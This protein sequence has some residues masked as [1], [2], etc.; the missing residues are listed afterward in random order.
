MPYSLVQWLCWLWWYWV[1]LVLLVALAVRVLVNFRVVVA[2]EVLVGLFVLDVSVGQCSEGC[3]RCTLYH[4]THWGFLES[5][6]FDWYYNCFYHIKRSK[7]TGKGFAF[8]KINQQSPYTLKHVH[9]N[10]L[11]V[12]IK[13]P[14]C[15]ECAQPEPQPLQVFQETCQIWRE[16]W[17]LMR[18]LNKWNQRKKLSVTYLNIQPKDTTWTNLYIMSLFFCCEKTAEKNTICQLRNTAHSSL[19]APNRSDCNI[20]ANNQHSGEPMITRLLLLNIHKEPDQKIRKDE[21]TFVANSQRPTAKMWRYLILLIPVL[22]QQTGSVA[23]GERLKLH[24]KWWELSF[25][26]FFSDGIKAAYT[27]HCLVRPSKHTVTENSSL[28]RFQKFF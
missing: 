28:S 6:L 16:Q 12:L 24:F 11:V 4:W 5:V 1:V 25:S 23:T 14:C 22:K 2:V 3:G 17:D 20:Y 18:K 19:N 10:F 13:F 26:H 8:W 21:I 9:S 7:I 27:S 15:G